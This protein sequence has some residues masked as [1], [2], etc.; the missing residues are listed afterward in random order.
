MKKMMKPMKKGRYAEGGGV[1][2]GRNANIDDD[3]RARAMAFVAGLN[4]KDE[5]DDGVKTSPV[6]APKAESRPLPKPAVK[7]PVKRTP[8][9]SGAVAGVPTS[10][11]RAPD[12]SGAMAG[13]PDAP[14]KSVPKTE[15]AMDDMGYSP[16]VTPRKTAE[17]RRMEQD[18]AL[19]PVRPEEVVVGGGALK[20]LN[21]AAQGI[22]ARQAARRA[23]KDEQRPV[24]DFLK[25]K[26]RPPRDLEEE[27]MAGEGGPNF[28][29][30]GAIKESPAMMKKEV[31]FMKAKGAPKSMLKH[32]MKEAKGMKKYAK[33]GA[34]RGDGACK[35]GHT[36]GRM[37]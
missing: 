35:R 2:E 24:P 36:K 17:M 29:K 18:Q 37:I 1:R 12:A 13:I 26:E 20:M 10:E 11:R 31:A 6:R 28:K 30:G 14:K 15:Y 25:K 8:D 5:D 23:A 34:V 21:K 4:R 16:E 22:A 3:T 9:A 19:K 7:K 33:G 27:R 32:E